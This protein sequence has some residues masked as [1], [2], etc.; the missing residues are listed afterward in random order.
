[1]VI[2]SMGV[3]SEKLLLKV[4]EA[5]KILSLSRSTV[6]SMIASGVLPSVRIGRAVRIPVD[7]LKEWVKRQTERDDLNA[8]E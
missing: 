5:Q 8:G 7:A 2:A 3:D 4:S 1:M 6:Y